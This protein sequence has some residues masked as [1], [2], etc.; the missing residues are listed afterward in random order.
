VLLEPVPGRDHTQ[1]VPGRDHTQHIECATVR[2]FTDETACV[3]HVAP[4]R[5]R[6]REGTRAMQIRPQTGAMQ[7]KDVMQL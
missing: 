6:E 5:C 4:G 1:H 2:H 3:R 7:R